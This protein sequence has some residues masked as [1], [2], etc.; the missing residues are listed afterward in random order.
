MT[1]KQRPA[2]IAGFLAAIGLF[3]FVPDWASFGDGARMQWAAAAQLSGPLAAAVF[4][5]IAAQ[6][7][8][9]GDRVAWLSFAAGSGLYLA[10]NLGYLLFYS[11]TGAPPAFPS[12]PEGAY[13][14]MALFF[15][16]GV[17][18]YSQMRKRF[19]AVQLYNFALIYCAVALASLF[20]LRP[21]I[22][23][24][25]MTPFSTVVAFLY[26]VL[27]FSVAAFG[28]VSFFLYD[29]GR[30]SMAFA[31]M[32]LAILAEAVADFRYALALMD[33]SYQIGG[34][35]QLLWVVSAGLLVCG[36]LEQIAI[37][38]Q[39]PQTI[40]FTRRTDRAVAQAAVPAA[41]VGAI[42][43]AA[44][45]TGFVGGGI[46]AWLAGT[47]AV[48]FALVAGLREHW[49]I[50][51][52][53]KLRRDLEAGRE[54][55]AL[56]QQRLT[57]VLE[58]TSDS[59]LV[60]DTEWNVVFFNHK[61]A[62]TINK[63]DLLRIGISVWDLFPAALTS[64]EG[65]HYFKAVKTRQPEEFEIFVDDRQIWLGIQAYPT[66]DG[67]SI[68]FRD[69]SEQKRARDEIAHLAL[70]DP[71]TGLANRTLFR[72]G[73][74]GALASGDDV[75][76]LLLD[77]DH[78]KEVNDTLGHPIGDAVLIGTAERMR[79][80]LGPDAT[81]GRLGGDEFAA[82]LVGQEGADELGVLAQRLLDGAH[83]PH[84][85]DGQSVR[86]GASMGIA[87]SSMGFETADELIK[88][89]DIALYAAKSEARGSFCFFEVAMQ[90][91][92]LQ[93][94]ALRTDLAG[95]LERGEFSLAYQPL[96]DL[97]L[98]RVTGFEALLR[99]QHPT[100]GPVAPDVFIPIAEETG[101]IVEIGRWVLRTACV[102]ATKWPGDISVAVNLSSRQFSAGDVSALVATALQDSGLSPARLELEITETVLLRDS[103]AN[104]AV[105]HGLRE[106]G[107]RIALDDFGTGFSSLA[108][109]QR[110]PF[111]KI[112]ID[113]AFISGLPANEESQAIVRSVIGLGQALGIRVTAEGVETEAQYD[114]VRN[115]CDEAQGYYL[116]R[117]VPATEI[118]VVIE[119]LDK[120]A[121]DLQRTKN[122][123][124]G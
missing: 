112:K 39:A 72:D 17:L 65:D 123:R 6:R 3:W 71:L 105:L 24:S 106:L 111:S 11:L 29:H 90:V 18:R 38:R 76:V 97:K 99:W 28:I 104:M 26:P 116:S 81:I 23:T 57:A 49:I 92:L 54:E 115:G 117:P 118:G 42:V 63:A 15:A 101:Q 14:L 48:G 19:G 25:V 119:R 35:T 13:F 120:R 53:R 56:S 22:A 86:I 113:R 66:E 103:N 46:Y 91:Q 93:K 34:P 95:A 67:L 9:G 52:Q 109:L 107:V 16:G 36:A 37:N 45:L 79:A 64:G 1:P 87:M 78:F 69:I 121:P 50:G 88:N 70:H 80:A 96:V 20:V 68:F 40:V 122:R 89:A 27:W 51:V 84:E 43:L 55:L 94:Q 60:L 58:S 44:S 73:L 114:W 77:L 41:A 62:E 10:G 75:A 83:A 82:I 7:S 102:E 5:W 2:M 98:N 31:L 32:V 30:K 47:L 59:V 8:S 100:R 12:L 110:F 108:Y 74:A 124:T 33:G 85:I 61:A 21:S 4:C